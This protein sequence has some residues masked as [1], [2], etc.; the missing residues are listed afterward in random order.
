MYMI[1]TFIILQSLF[2]FDFMSW[3]IYIY[4][5]ILLIF[6]FVF[7]VFLVFVF[8]CSGFQTSNIKYLVSD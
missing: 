5:Y 7:V 1:D 8:K 4:I 6:I 2:Y 3:Y